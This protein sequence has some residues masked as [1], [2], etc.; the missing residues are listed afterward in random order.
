[1]KKLTVILLLAFA[2]LPVF[3]QM[4]GNPANWCRQGFFPRES[5]DY[6][7][8]RI[9]GD[10]KER[11]YFYDDTRDDCPAGKG[12][13]SKSYLVPEDTVLISRIY[14]SDWGCAWYVPKKGS[15]TVGW[16]RFNRLDFLPS[17]LNAAAQDFAG[18]WKYFD[19][20]I[21]IARAGGALTV[22]GNAVWKGLGDNVHIGELDYKGNPVG[23]VL[24][25]GDDGEYECRATIRL[26]AQYLVV[27]D[28][29]NCGGANV[30]F[31]GVYK[32]ASK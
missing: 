18:K 8:A 9:N 23:N 2:A 6:Q 26:V 28:N 27:S 24:K 13:V 1:M 3:A 11:A 5:E 12:C 19:N 15:P 21:E 7:V 16:I 4:D 31:S 22:K 32:K 14:N 29:M 10:A 20:S 25:V 30:S 17:T